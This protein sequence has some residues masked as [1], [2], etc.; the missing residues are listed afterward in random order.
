[1]ITK[2]R[3]RV[4]RMEKNFNVICAIEAKEFHALSFNISDTGIGLFTKKALHLDDS[5]EM[6]IYPDDE[7]F[8]FTCDGTV[9]HNSAIGT[10]FFRAISTTR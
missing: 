7:L 5:F 3:R 9:R 8:T 10:S 2:E 1:M 4:Q 6:K